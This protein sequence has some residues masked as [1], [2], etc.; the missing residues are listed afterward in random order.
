MKAV[1]LIYP[2]GKVKEGKIYATLRHWCESTGMNYNTLN[3]ARNF[4]KASGEEY[5]FE[6]QGVVIQK[7][8][9]NR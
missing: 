5:N 1:Y 6:F 3:T 2:K 4:A 7:M 9:V 8:L